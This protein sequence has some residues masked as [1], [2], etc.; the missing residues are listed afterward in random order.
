[1]FVSYASQDSAVAEGL[2]AA[3]ERDGITCWIAPRDVR[4]GDF[5]ADAIV[6]AINACQILVLV[7]SASS[8]ASPHVLREVERASA[9]RRAIITFRIDA[10]AL[11]PGLEYFLSASQW[12]DASLGGAAHAFPKLSDAINRRHAAGA[13][14]AASAFVGAPASL[15]VDAAP[16]PAG[17]TAPA[18]WLNRA[19]LAAVVVIGIALAYVL[20]DRF[21]LSRHTL[22][23]TAANGAAPP[24]SAAM[25]ATVPAS[26]KSIV[27][28]PF[29]DL[30]EQ[31]DQEYFSDGLSEELID[32]LGKIPGLRVPA[33]TSSF[34]FKD[35]QT[36][37][38]EIAQSLKVAH[39]LEGSVRKAGKNVRITADLVRVS[40][41]AH[42]WSETYDRK[43]D[44]I[45]KLQDEIAGA[46][47]RA[48]KVSLLASDAPKT[49]PAANIDA[50]T[51]YLQ[52]RSLY[53]RFNLADNL[54]AQDYLQQAIKLDPKFAP[55]WAELSRARL[56][57][58][59]AFGASSFEDSHAAALE[60]ANQ[61]LKL[62]PNLALGHVAMGQVL[63]VMDWDWDAAERE[64]KTGM[65]LDP[66]DADI[67]V[68]A[69]QLALSQG[70]SEE[71]RQLAQS[72][73]ARDPL[74]VPTYRQ[75][76][77]ANYFAGKLAE[78]EAAFRKAIDLN[79]ASD[80]LR[81]KLALVLLSGGDAQGALAEFEREPH[82]GW[83]QQ[84]LPLALDAL[85]RKTEADRAIAL[86]EKSGA[87]G[88]AYQLAVIYAHRKSFD[89]AFTWLNRAYQ[90]HDAGLATY[91]K[92][93]PMLQNIRGDPR[94]SA[95]LHKLKLLE[96]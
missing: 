48:L 81:Y 84:G 70:R 32:L 71:A 5:Y 61:A 3:L 78:A 9:K 1:V 80:G 50:Y 52:G 68:L 96:K 6:Q 20:A 10:A 59:A 91:V 19:L 25:S 34:Y 35:K 11:P 51:L 82:T 83:R 36:T 43:L 66:G 88:W 27:V 42:L 17:S 41:E 31:K 33:R 12:L 21:W 22:P 38:G 85:G 89:L 47:V 37:L 13:D 65:E 64:L 14:R 58:F 26:D 94:Y 40:D 8:I 56:I 16:Q 62:D 95:F 76:G 69:S 49:T 54:K 44:D 29:R 24:T 74:G 63:F 77:N 15:L 7:L 23:S 2:C 87:E 86:A 4:P 39:V 30:S 73:V 79:P 60:T 67:L 45:F 46:V 72:A 18:G 75:L 93:D 55:A 53:E 57:A 92:A 28:L 90:Q